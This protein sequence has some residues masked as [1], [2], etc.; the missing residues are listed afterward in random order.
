MKT[1]F[2]PIIIMGL[3][4]I[5]LQV[6]GLRQL[7]TVF[8]G[9]ELDIGITLSVWLTAVGIGSYTG[10]KLKF[11]H[12]FAMSFLSVAFLSQPTILF[13]NLIRPLLPLEFGETIP[14]TTTII[15]TIISLL[16]L[17][18]VIGL[19]FPLSVSYLRGKTAKAYG[20]E[21]AGAFIGGALFTL[22]LSGRA[23]VFVLSAAIS[24]INFI[25]ALL[26]LRKRSLIVLLLIPVIFYSGGNKINAMVYLEG[27]K[28]IERVESRY[29]EIMVLKLRDQSNV[30]ASGKFQF[31]YPDPQTEELKAHL[32][33]SVHPS[34]SHILVI[35]GSPAVL[36]EFLKY[37]HPDIDFL[38]IDPKIIE[39]SLRLLSREDREILRDK[40]VRI[41][42][43]DARKFVKALHA[44][45][46]DL[47][48]LNLPEP[49]TA[50]INRFYTTDFFTEAEAVLKDDGILCLT[51]PTSS[52]YISRKMQMANGSV[53]NS[54]KK[55]FGHV[56]VSS[57]EY[58][59]IFASNS[60]FDIT[61]PT[62][63]D[64][65]FKRA[66]DARYFQPYI[67]S[68]AFSPL[69]VKMVRER[70]EKVDV[71]NRDMKPIAYLYNLMLWSE[72][73]G[74]RMLNYL[75]GL[76]G[77]QIIL[78]LITA[79]IIMAAILWR[80]KQ[81]IYYS[82]FTTG[83]STMAFSLIIILTYQALYGYVYE[84]IGLLTAIFMI[85]IAIGAHAVR[86]ILRPL[87]LLRLFELTAI[88]LF[89]SSPLLFKREILFYVLSLLCGMIGGIQFATAN[90]CMK[91]SNPPLPPLLRESEGGLSETT[92]IAGRLYAVD[93]AGSF[94][95][96]FLA[97]I[98]LMPLLG[99]QNAL[100]FLALIKGISLALLLSIKER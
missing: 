84:M 27:L 39:V 18:F 56:E 25:T 47:V 35:G 16:P 37:Q 7:L 66:I 5:L 21:A 14:L 90:L 74:G 57:E 72:V 46:Y 58:G 80:R 44:R 50:N 31:S 88:L 93:L 78:M 33:M 48:I 67:L 94:F 11:K 89:I 2:L 20:L 40:R 81:S 82:M 1:R 29:G 100:L 38:E 54:I 83:Y 8:S 97:A 49:S 42:T 10:Y 79:F 99:V 3:S 26:L 63:S 61:P 60:P 28:L 91:F 77:W 64:R 22:L 76:K 12:A 45:N 32:P 65:F 41:I 17:C 87:R 51:L 69:K 55:V 34:P 75:F 53:Y 68:D 70:L 71:T 73:H 36:R 24:I 98:F 43:E 9:N 15:F 85:G 4:S 6:T 95:G 13:I 86:N 52:G 96:A 62:L 59:Y 19:Q 92:R 23:D 30:Y